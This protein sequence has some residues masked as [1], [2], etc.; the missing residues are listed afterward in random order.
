MRYDFLVMKGNEYLMAL[1]EIE[2][3]VLPIF[4]IYKYDAARLERRADAY[5]VKRKL[6]RPDEQW[7]LVAFNWATGEVKPA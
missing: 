5:R 1:A 4:T 2:G 3:K 6:Q 7:R